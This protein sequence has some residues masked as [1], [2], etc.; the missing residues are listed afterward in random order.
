[1]TAAIPL[2]P[3]LP[4]LGS[5]RSDLTRT[6]SLARSSVRHHSIVLL[7][8]D[9]YA[10]P[11]SSV[12][13][14]I[15]PWVEDEQR[16]LHARVAQNPA[17]K[18]M[19]LRHF[20]DMLVWLRVVLAQDLA[21]RYNDS[22]G[23]FIFQAAPFNSDEFRGFARGVHAQLGDIADMI[24][25]TVKALPEH[26]ACTVRAGMEHM[27]TENRLHH[28][29]LRQQL[30]LLPQTGNSP[31][32]TDT[33]SPLAPLPINSSRPRRP[34]VYTDGNTNR[35]Q[36]V[37]SVQTCHTP[38]FAADD[39]LHALPVPAFQQEPAVLVHPQACVP[40]SLQHAASHV[41]HSELPFPATLPS[42]ATPT[43]AAASRSFAVSP[44]PAASPSP[45]AE[46]FRA[47]SF[48]AASP[49]A[50]PHNLTLFPT[51]YR[52]PPT[53]PPPFFVPAMPD[54]FARDGSLPS[55]LTPPPAAQDHLSIPQRN[56]VE[57][58]SQFPR[59]QLLQHRWIFNQSLGRWCPRYTWPCPATL[60]ELWAEYTC[61]V[62]GYLP[63][64]AMEKYWCTAW[65]SDNKTE[66]SRRKKVVELLDTVAKRRSCTMERVFEFFEARYRKTPQRPLTP[67]QLY[68][69]ISRLKEE[70][71]LLAADEYLI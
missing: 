6:S 56:W 51:V 53:P 26:V 49:P 37:F 16:A 47:V 60:S 17:F 9:R 45:T 68:D 2:K 69:T 34:R 12:L 1:M 55:G 22:P 29:A 50:P 21:V 33:R 23:A 13:E 66:W 71:I 15:F 43:F 24:K 61:G 10:E 35:E 52:P 42:P 62:N 64:R 3:S 30:A 70:T 27:V 40:H 32:Q 8:T 65:R 39:G 36:S 19:S 11:P 41:W 25:Q 5:T 63:V 46:P 54:I 31:Q 44:F 57:I 59:D 38:P 18:D 58:C 7:C 48:P 67:R 28:E 4:S 14:Q 20:L